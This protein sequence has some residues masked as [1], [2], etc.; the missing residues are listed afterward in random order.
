MGA[1]WPEG[2]LGDELLGHEVV[3]EGGTAGVELV[4]LL[5]VE[6]G[7]LLVTFVGRGVVLMVASTCHI[8]VG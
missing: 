5:D 4:H 7:L 6:E 2:M 8:L 3:V 1:I